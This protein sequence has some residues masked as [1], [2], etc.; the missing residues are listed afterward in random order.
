MEHRSVQHSSTE[1]ASRHASCTTRRSTVAT[2]AA[3]RLLL[4]LLLL[5][6]SCRCF[7]MR[8]ARDCDNLRRRRITRKN[9]RRFALHLRLH[10]SV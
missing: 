3:N 9:D 10:R 7:T 2:A 1:L 6:R 5:L 8:R 4:L